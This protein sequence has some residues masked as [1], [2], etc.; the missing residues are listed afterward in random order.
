MFFAALRAEGTRTGD[1]APRVLLSDEPQSEAR[2][3]VLL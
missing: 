2:L 3:D 1:G